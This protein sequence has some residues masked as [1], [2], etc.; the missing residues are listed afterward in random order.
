[1]ADASCSVRRDP[2]SVYLR[3]K[4]VWNEGWLVFDRSDKN[5]QYQTDFNL[6][7]AEAGVGR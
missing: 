7:Q 1:M 4:K 6:G 5:H 3:R 2:F